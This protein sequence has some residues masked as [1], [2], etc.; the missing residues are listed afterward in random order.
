MC[1]LKQNDIY[2]ESIKELAEEVGLIYSG[3]NFDGEPEFI[4][5]T[6]A[7]DKF[8]KLSNKQ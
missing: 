3:R 4:G 7:W 5:T 8:T 2:E 1:S 6:K